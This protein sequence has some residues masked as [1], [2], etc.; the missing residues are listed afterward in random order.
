MEIGRNL[1]GTL[2]GH[3]HGS[4]RLLPSI[5]VNVIG[6]GL[7]LNLLQK[8][9]QGSPEWLIFGLAAL[10]CFIVPVW[11]GVGLVRASS[12]YVRETGDNMLPWGGYLVL[13]AVV[14]ASVS[15]TI[16]SVLALPRFQPP[17]VVAKAPLVLPIVDQGRTVQ[18]AGEID[19]AILTA[20][21]DAL[22]RS[23]EIERV[24]LQSDGGLIYAA[25]AI[26]GVVQE[27]RLNSHVSD[28]CA[29]ACTLIFA[30]GAERTM[31]EEAR[32]GFHAYGKRTPNHILMVDAG[33]EQE[34]DVAYLQSRGI[35]DGFLQGMYRVE[36]DDMWFPDRETLV[37]AGFLTRR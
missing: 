1:L 30:A 15:Q 20:F 36:N 34:K 4:S 27:Y 6:V 9:A 29:S 2:A 8:Q 10:G 19:Y 25:R 7:G 32:L 17:P 3:W 13:V 14:L 37:D 23:P 26:A 31:S 24:E 5:L 12:A 35:S 18:I 21:R 28:V 22:A 11:Q 16:G 33:Q